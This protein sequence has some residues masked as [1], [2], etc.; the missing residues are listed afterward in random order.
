MDLQLQ[1]R[2]YVSDLGVGQDGARI[3]YCYVTR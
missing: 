1:C 2:D 3:D